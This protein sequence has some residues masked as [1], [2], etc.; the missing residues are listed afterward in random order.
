MLVYPIEYYEGVFKDFQGKIHDLR[1]N[2][3]G[4]DGKTY[5]RPS[6]KTFESLGKATLLRYLQTAYKAQIKEL[7]SPSHKP[8]DQLFEQEVLL[9]EL[10]Q[11]LAGVEQAM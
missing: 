2:G 7:E 1:P 4:T 6:L 3:K 8:Y 10:K 9:V 5:V 11:K